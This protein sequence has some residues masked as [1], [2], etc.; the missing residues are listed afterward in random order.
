M[1]RGCLKIVRGWG[2]ESVKRSFSWLRALLKGNS[3]AESGWEERLGDAAGEVGRS[4]PRIPAGL[5]D[6]FAPLVHTPTLCQ[7]DP[8][9]TLTRCHPHLAASG[10][11]LTHTGE[12]LGAQQDT[13][14]SGSR[15]RRA[16]TWV[17]ARAGQKGGPS[18]GNFISSLNLARLPPA[19]YPSPYH[20]HTP[21]RSTQPVSTLRN[22]LRQ[23]P[24]RQ[25]HF[26]AQ[27]P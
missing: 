24:S 6:S 25:N 8:L 1:G 9:S 14:S 10:K 18:R 2:K 4:W 27:N 5:H 20:P 11:P 7:P 3:K 13:D 26:L 15:E 22:K 17:G 16:R 21:C 19:L 23:S 12:D